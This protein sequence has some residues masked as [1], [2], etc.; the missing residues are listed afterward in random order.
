[1]GNTDKCDQT[2]DIESRIIRAPDGHLD[3]IL[4]RLKVIA[5]KDASVLFIGPTGTGKE[6]LAAYLVEQ[7]P[8]DGLREKIYNKI[9]CIGFPETMI[10]GELFGHTKGAFTGATSDHIGLIEA[11]NGGTLFLD[12][13]GV[14]PNPSLAKLLRVLEE[15]KVRKLGENEWKEVS[16]RFIAATNREDLNIDL[17][18]RFNFLIEI[19]P[20][21]KRR[22]D[23]PYLFK[24]F[25]ENSPFKSIELGSL[26][27]FSVQ[28]WEGNVRDF[29]RVLRDTEVDLDIAMTRGDISQ[30]DP[31]AF[32]FF[33][34]LF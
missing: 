10:D 21:N 31:D 18:H 6:L 13:I 9:N 34:E 27:E 7:T 16:V 24:H 8:K 29:R 20:L 30:D 22:E 3:S 11:S 32:V 17:K 15:K 28:G 33:W 23:I 25:L 14:L 26:F 2:N 4:K 12:E 5:A 1:M 19:L